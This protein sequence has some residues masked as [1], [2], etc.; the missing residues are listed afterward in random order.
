MKV[1]TLKS[2]GFCKGVKNAVDTVLSCPS[3]NTYILGEL[4]HNEIIVNQ[5]KERGI[6]TVQNVTEVPDGATLIIRSHGAEKY[7]FDEC[8][9][10]DIKIIDCTCPFVKKIA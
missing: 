1:I 7:V 3:E 5:I 2:N 8:L 6:T 4:I 9:K 10:R